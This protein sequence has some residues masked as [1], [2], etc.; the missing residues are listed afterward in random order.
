MRGRE[1][2]GGGGERIDA[3]ID[4]RVVIEPVSPMMSIVGGGEHAAW[5]REDGR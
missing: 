1:C 5:W 3:T 2:V 4:L